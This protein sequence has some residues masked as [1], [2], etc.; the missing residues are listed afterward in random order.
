MGGSTLQAK[1]N[2]FILTYLISVSSIRNSGLVLANRLKVRWHS[3]VNKIDHFKLGNTI[4]A[5]AHTFQ[6]AQTVKSL[7]TQNNG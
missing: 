4:S 2:Q 3:A 7:S 6:M 5:W 1:A